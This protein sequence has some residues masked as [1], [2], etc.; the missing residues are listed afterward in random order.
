M[1]ARESKHGPDMPRLW[2]VIC[3]ACLILAQERFEAELKRRSASTFSTV[4]TPKRNSACRLFD[5]FVARAR[6]AAHRA[7]RLGGLEIEHRF[8]LDNRQCVLSASSFS[9]KAC[10]GDAGGLVAL[11]LGNRTRIYL[12]GIILIARRNSRM[13]LVGFL[14]TD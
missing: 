1:H 12:E 6:S 8:V 2:L 10:G 11:D 4:S 14:L 9:A 5:H 3:R 13:T 7:E